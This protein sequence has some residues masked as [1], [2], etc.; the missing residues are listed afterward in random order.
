MKTENL[1]CIV[2]SMLT[3]TASVELFFFYCKVYHNVVFIK[4]VLTLPFFKQFFD[5][6][7]QGLVL[8]SLQF[9]VKKSL[10]VFFFFLK[11]IL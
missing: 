3:A 5:I 2:L 9:K 8:P 10:S 1:M 6:K 7:R 4:M 11:F